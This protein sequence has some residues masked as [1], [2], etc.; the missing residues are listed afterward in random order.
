MYFTCILKFAAQIAFLYQ[1]DLKRTPCLQGCCPS[2]LQH[3]LPIVIFQLWRPPSG[4]WICHRVTRACDSSFVAKQRPRS[5][6]A[7]GIWKPL[8]LESLPQAKSTSRARNICFYKHF[9]PD[10]FGWPQFLLEP[11]VGLTCTDNAPLYFYFKAWC[12][13]H[14]FNFYCHATMSISSVKPTNLL[15]QLKI[16]PGSRHNT[17]QHNIQIQARKSLS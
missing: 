9:V 17:F 12:I 3:V 13:H 1:P 4:S 5:S 11:I 10:P 2:F 15:I 16:V 14:Q 6:S 8:E 7:H